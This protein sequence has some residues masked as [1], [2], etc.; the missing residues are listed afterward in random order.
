MHFRSYILA[1]R[2][3]TMLDFLGPVNK[4]SLRIVVPNLSIKQHKE[5]LIFYFS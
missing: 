3:L 5:F 2:T 1:A 4:V